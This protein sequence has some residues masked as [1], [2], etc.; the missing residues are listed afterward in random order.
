MSFKILILLF[1]TSTCINLAYSQGGDYSDE[2]SEESSEEQYDDDNDNGGLRRIVND[3]PQ[4]HENFPENCPFGERLING[5][6]HKRPEIIFNI[7]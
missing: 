6:C 7:Q 5:V 4:I 2:S 3:V 1:V